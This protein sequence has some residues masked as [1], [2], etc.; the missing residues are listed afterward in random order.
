VGVFSFYL[1]G[2]DS[3]IK[4]DSWDIKI[5]AQFPENSILKFLRNYEIAWVKSICVGVSL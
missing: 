1:N 4:A 3:V 5:L 2:T